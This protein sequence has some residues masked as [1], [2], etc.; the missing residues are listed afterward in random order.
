MEPICAVYRTVAHGVSSRTSATP[1]L[2]PRES[3]AKLKRFV[4]LID[5]RDTI[6]RALRSSEGWLAPPD[7][8]R[9]AEHQKRVLSD[10]LLQ[11]SHEVA[12]ILRA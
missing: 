6:D 8:I 11:G 2:A 9:Q 5:E 7:A 10:A 1:T 4:E 12:E 3:V